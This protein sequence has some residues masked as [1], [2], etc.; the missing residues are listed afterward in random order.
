MHFPDKQAHQAAFLTFLHYA[1][2]SVS[3][4]TGQKVDPNWASQTAVLQGFA[5]YQGPDIVIREDRMALGLA[6]L[7][8]EVGVPAPIYQPD[9]TAAN[10]LNAVYAPS[11]EAACE[12]AYTRDYIAQGWTR[13]QP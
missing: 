3:G 11:F 6:W 12:D 2:L 5:G 7:A 9:L 13:W 4:Q 8:A 10:A 1:K